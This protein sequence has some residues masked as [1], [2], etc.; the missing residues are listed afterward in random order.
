MVN[1]GTMD[2]CERRRLGLPA[3]AFSAML[4]AGCSLIVE[5]QRQQ[6]L[7][8]AD[9]QSRD[10]VYADA[11]CVQSVCQP[12]P[13]WSC[14]G[15]VTWPQPPP[16]KAS[17]V[18]RLR[19]LVTD[20]PVAGVTG[21]VCNKLDFDC[22]R[23]LA[24]GLVSDGSGTIVFEL[25]AGFDGFVEFGPL[26]RMP[27]VYFFYPPV[28]GDR[29]FPSLPLMAE[30]ELSFFASQGGR[31]IS[32]DRG[33]LM[34]GSYDC[35]YRPAD[36]VTLSSDDADQAT[37]P[38]YLVKKVPSFTVEATDSSGRGG[39]INLR[40]GSVSVTGSLASDQ[41]RI[42]TVGVFVRPGTITYTTL[43]PAPK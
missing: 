5:P 38:F 16:R 40:P 18:F 26:G 42:A 28:T 24:G 17:I 13:A 29:E 22:A 35:L 14:L 23:P 20:A 2:F 7:I 10:P 8:D 19:D 27:S 15:D 3:V 36:G 43:L 25:D 41:R 9:C 34:L 39:M 4:A 6:C 12:N 30:R 32:P 31:P 11:V 37:A 21:R 1:G 33:H